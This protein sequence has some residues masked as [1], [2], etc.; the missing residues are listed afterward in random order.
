MGVAVCSAL[1]PLPISFVST[2][3]VANTFV[4][5][6]V[7][8]GT[9]YT[10]ELLLHQAHMTGQSDLETL[11]LVVGGKWWKVRGRI[12]DPLRAPL[13]NSCTSATTHRTSRSLFCR[14]GAVLLL[15]SVLLSDI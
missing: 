6:V 14:V 2:G 13:S 10:S 5:I 7:A 15:E 12:S 9:L 3:V 4:M 8:A 11:C 1:F